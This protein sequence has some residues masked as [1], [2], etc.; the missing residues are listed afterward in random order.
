MGVV[1]VNILRGC[2]LGER[3]DIFLSNARQGYAALLDIMCVI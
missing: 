1:W 3:G 2:E